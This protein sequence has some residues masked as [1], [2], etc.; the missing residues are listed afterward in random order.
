MN[1]SCLANLS[2]VR[3]INS[4]FPVS[5]EFD[6]D[7][8]F[9]LQKFLDEAS[10]AAATV[11][12]LNEQRLPSLPFRLRLF[13]VSL[14]KYFNISVTEVCIIHIVRQKCTFTPL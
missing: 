7:F 13:T 9:P 4:F 2:S 12:S 5:F 1:N 3:F 6:L 11:Q 10:A 8:S 14:L